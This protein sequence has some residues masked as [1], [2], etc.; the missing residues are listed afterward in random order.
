M[1]NGVRIA[2][3][4]MWPLCCGLG[5]A[6][7]PDSY[8]P[9]NV[10]SYSLHVEQWVTTDTAKVTVQFD[11]ALTAKGSED[12]Q[13]TLLQKLQTVS[14]HGKWYITHVSQT[15]D[16]ADLQRISLRAE[17]RLSIHEV[18]FLQDKV[19]S[20]SKPGATFTIADID[21]S[22]SAED[23]SRV[24]VTLRMQLYQMAKDEL[25]RL[26]QLYPTSHFELHK[27]DIADDVPS[28][29]QPLMAGDAMNN[30]LAVKMAG[31]NSLSMMVNRK[32]QMNARVEYA[33][34]LS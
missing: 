6:D 24:K 18:S 4:L 15:K 33:S 12:L 5:W 23:I 8:P 28:N 21:F 19:K 2:I 32:I 14:A 26:L 20:L 10:I 25:Q 13:S 11:G 9:L 16:S 1:K 31:A 29:P 27:V 34:E 17:A 3:L 22:P 30:V 7:Y